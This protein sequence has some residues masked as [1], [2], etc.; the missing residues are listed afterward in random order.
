MKKKI[1]I[2]AYARA[3]VEKELKRLQKKAKMYGSKLDWAFSNPHVEKISYYVADPVTG[4][5]THMPQRT[6]S[7]DA[8]DLHLDSEIISMNGW[9]VLARVEDI[10]DKKVVDCFTEVC[11]PQWY[12]V[13]MHC[14]HCGTNRKRS[15]VFI[16]KHEDGREVQV[17]RTC[18]KDFT[19][20]DPRA[21]V[22]YGSL[23]WA[24][25]SGV[26]TEFL[27]D[28]GINPDD[29]MIK[30]RY[31]TTKTII[32]LAV[33]T[34]SREGYKKSSEQVSTKY[35]VTSKLLEGDYPS[36]DAMKTAEAICKWIDGEKVRENDNLM[37]NCQTLVKAKIAKV[38][39]IGYLVYLPVAYGKALEARQNQNTINSEYVGEVGERLSL[40]IKTVKCLSLGG[41]MYGHYNIKET[42]FWRMTDLDGNALIW[43]TDKNLAQIAGIEFKMYNEFPVT[44]SLTGTVKEHNEYK[45]EKQTVMTRCR[46]VK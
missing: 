27:G 15:C 13:D 22:E 21:V 37:R 19:G 34:I 32:A 41:Y 26:Y 20:I 33:D 40:E 7:V 42:Y 29:E 1:T 6:F 31:Y 16:C 10:N 24:V 39:M 45:G 38:N 2:Y 46:V 35:Q 23:K 36:E 14:D 17:G 12:K 43:K 30:C 28:D 8:I 25:V 11:K 9:T 18:L 5:I 3:D 4:T 44:F